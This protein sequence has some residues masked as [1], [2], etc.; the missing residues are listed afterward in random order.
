MFDFGLS[1]LYDMSGGDHLLRKLRTY[2]ECRVK[3]WLIRWS[4]VHYEAGLPTF[5]QSLLLP[6][7]EP[8]N[9]VRKASMQDIR[10]I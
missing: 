8:A 7:D 9:E 1:K 2:G 10:A 5:M 4:E 3:E 6:R